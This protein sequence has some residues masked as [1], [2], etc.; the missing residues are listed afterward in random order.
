[1]DSRSQV[2][3]RRVPIGTE[4][5]SDLVLPSLSLIPPVGS[6]PRARIDHFHR[7]TDRSALPSRS[8]SPDRPRASRRWIPDVCCRLLTPNA[9]DSRRA[10]TTS[11]PRPRSTDPLPVPL[12]A[13]P[14]SIWGTPPAARNRAKRSFSEGHQ[15]STHYIL[16][17]ARAPY[18]KILRSPR[19]FLK[20]TLTTGKVFQELRIG[21]TRRAGARWDGGRSAPPLERR[22]RVSRPLSSPGSSVNIRPLQRLRLSVGVCARRATSPAGR[23]ASKHCA[24]R[25]RVRFLP[26]VL[27]SSL[28]RGRTGAARQRALRRL[29]PVRSSRYH[30]LPP[31]LALPRRPAGSANAVESGADRSLPWSPFAPSPSAV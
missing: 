5:S 20:N 12:T 7:E 24:R 4:L 16:R 14:S 18:Y 22:T 30:S 17:K 1:M 19:A 26:R 27:F 15:R 29:L 8:T 6:Q 13:V 21:E 2:L 10:R 9:R 28:G 25:A 11:P 23:N 3:E 31:P